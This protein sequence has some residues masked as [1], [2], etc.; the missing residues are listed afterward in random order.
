MLLCLY[1]CANFS[2]IVVYDCVYVNAIIYIAV[3]MGVFLYMYDCVR[4]AYCVCVSLCGRG[5]VK[6]RL[7][8]SC[9][10]VV[11]CLG[12]PAINTL[13]F[14]MKLSSLTLHKRKSLVSAM[15]FVI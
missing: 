4:E 7:S 15:E 8:L 9:L 6:E 3:C 2:A 12:Q 13:F 1:D 14:S 11:V 10:C 5:I